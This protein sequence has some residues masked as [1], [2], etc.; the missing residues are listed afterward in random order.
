[1][2]R[3]S[4]HCIYL[5]YINPNL[6]VLNQLANAENFESPQHN[7]SGRHKTKKDIDGNKST[8]WRE[9]LAHQETHTLI[10][11]LGKSKQSLPATKTLVIVSIEEFDDL[12]QKGIQQILQQT[13]VAESSRWAPRP[14][15]T[16]GKRYRELAREEANLR[17]FAFEAAKQAKKAGK[18][19]DVKK[20]CA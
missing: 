9:S 13:F 17:K 5:E 1:M 3:F 20:V 2:R 14:T 7:R 11:I 6:L 4:F 16:P 15:D 8:T 19:G 12:L 10:D 18:W